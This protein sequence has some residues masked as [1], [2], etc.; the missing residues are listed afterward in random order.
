MISHIHD[1]LIAPFV[2]FE[3]MRR[4]LAAVVALSLGDAVF[5]V[6]LILVILYA[7]GE[8]PRDVFF[9]RRSVVPEIT[10]GVPLVFVALGIGMIVLLPI[11]QFAPWLPSS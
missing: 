3:F 7:H 6:G 11:R 5:L 8:R 2:D 4:A 1:A 9:G 10:V